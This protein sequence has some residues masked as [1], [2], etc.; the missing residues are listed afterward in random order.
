MKHIRIIV[1]TFFFDGLLWK[2]KN[3][4]YALIYTSDFMEIL[5]SDVVD[6]SDTIAVVDFAELINANFWWFSFRNSTCG[7]AC[8]LFS[9]LLIYIFSVG[10]TWIIFMYSNG[11][12]IFYFTF[13]SQ[14][15]C[16][17]WFSIC[18]NNSWQLSSYRRIN[19]FF[20][21]F[22]PF[23]TFFVSFSVFL[24]RFII[25]ALAAYTSANT[26]CYIW[27]YFNLNKILV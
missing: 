1:I 4:W 6:M 22:F 19:I 24:L 20:I 10:S 11:T 21:I 15:S 18:F 8:N 5:H 17:L 25:I 7:C 9:F 12:I 3:F 27:F 2:S 26:H 14:F 16:Y 13:V 23:F